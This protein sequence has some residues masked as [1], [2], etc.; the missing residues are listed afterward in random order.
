M[1]GTYT[2]VAIMTV[3]VLAALIYG[4]ASEG[5]PW[6]VRGY[7]L[8]DTRVSDF[9]TIQEAVLEYYDAN[10]ALPQSFADIA[11]STEGAY[12]ESEGIFKDPD[13]GQPYD[14][15]LVDQTHYQLCATFSASSEEEQQSESDSDAYLYD[16]PTTQQHTGGYDCLSYSVPAPAPAPAYPQEDYYPYQGAGIPVATTT[17]ATST[18]T[19]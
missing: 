14:Y 12:Y 7:K 13:T 2:A 6:A 9:S 19:Y 18:Y 11:S 4:F 3:I 1:K 15:K 8:D 5:S 16:E 10:Q 17:K